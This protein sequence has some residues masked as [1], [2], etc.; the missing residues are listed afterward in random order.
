MKNV[1]I[2]ID[3]I[4]TLNWMH[5]S[6][7]Y[8]AYY[9]QSNLNFNIYLAYHSDVSMEGGK[10]MFFSRNFIIKDYQKNK[11]IL[12]ERE[13][14]IADYFEYVLIRLNPPFDQK[15]LSLCW[16]LNFVDH[17]K[18]L[19]INHPSSLINFS[20]KLVVNNFS[21]EYQLPQLI[22]CDFNEIEK[23]LFQQ[24]KVVLKPVNNFGGFDVF[25]V[26]KNDVNLKA[27]FSSL[28]EKYENC[29][30]IAQKFYPKISQ[31][32]DKRILMVNG[33]V[34]G[35]F[36]RKPKE[37]SILVG[38]IFGGSHQAS[39]LS[40]KEQ[41]ICDDIGDFLRKNK[42]YLAGIDVIGG[43]YLNEINITSPTGLISLERIYG[44]NAAKICWENFEQIYARL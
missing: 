33:K 31:E 20:E 19:V 23:F 3:Q 15:Y 34:L 21:Q 8:L 6:S 18:T 30:I 39:V 26:D 17:S 41:K 35:C 25:V 5:D 1:L 29:Q 44:N 16:I 37:G 14:R 38:L 11:F 9:A 2:V 24:G 27:I 32:G 36:T 13:K 22:S 10:V 42:I 40:R 7:L 4:E 28:M 12:G 43:E